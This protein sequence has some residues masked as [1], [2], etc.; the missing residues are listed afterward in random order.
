MKIFRHFIFFIVICLALI[1]EATFFSR[2]K[3]FGANPNIILII[4][5]SM[6]FFISSRTAIFYAGVAGLLEDLFIGSLIGSNLLALVIVIYMVRTY[7]SRVIRENIITPLII[8]FTSSI[9]Y[10]FL[11]GA[12]LLIAGRGY[13]LNVVFMQNILYGSIYNLMIALIIYPI[14]YLVLHRF[15]GEY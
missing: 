6:S 1:I 9:T 4:I 2:L 12:I 10:Y 3:F 13:F 5:V 7:S 11:M 14:C 8:V 15:K